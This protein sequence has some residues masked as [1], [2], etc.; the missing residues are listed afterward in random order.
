[1]APACAADIEASPTAR[2]TTDVQAVL[3]LVPKMEMF[4][5]VVVIAVHDRR[6]PERSSNEPPFRLGERP[7]SS[8][9]KSQFESDFTKLLR[10]GRSYRRAHWV[11]MKDGSRLDEVARDRACP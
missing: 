2:P 3:I 7:G 5:C 9:E 4:D 1:M 11:S 6:L 10:P 8:W